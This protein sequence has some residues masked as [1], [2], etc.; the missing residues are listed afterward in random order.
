MSWSGLG[1]GVSL[2]VE[3]TVNIRCL[4]IP[5]SGS[6]KLKINLTAGKMAASQPV[7]LIFSLVMQKKRCRRIL[8][9][10]I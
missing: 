7:K 6:V 9:R 10:S 2:D 1:L 3:G 4:I 5:G 8:K